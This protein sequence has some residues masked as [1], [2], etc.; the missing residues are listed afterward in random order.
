M[1]RFFHESTVLGS[2]ELAKVFEAGQSR[3]YDIQD[4][5]VVFA[6]DS[7]IYR[8]SVWNETVSSE[9]ISLF[10]STCQSMSL[11][12]QTNDGIDMIKF[13]RAQ[14]VFRF[15]M[16]YFSQGLSFSDP[17]DRLSFIK[18]SHQFLS[19]MAEQ[20]SDFAIPSLSSDTPVS[21]FHQFLAFYNLS[22]LVIAFQFLEIARKGSLPAMQ[23]FKSEEYVS[24]AAESLFQLHYRL[25][26][27]RLHPLYEGLRSFHQRET[28]IKSEGWILESCVIA[29]LTLHQARIDYASYENLS[30]L[31]VFGTKIIQLRNVQ[32]LEKAWQTIFTLLPLQ[33]VDQY[34]FV[35]RGF[36]LHFLTDN[37]TTV[38]LMVNRVLSL[39]LA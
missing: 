7:K 10:R 30:R 5:N 18:W 31:L 23:E 29:M 17:V 22:R 4:G 26:L 1:L 2:G 3:D 6:Q 33:E 15:F 20:F 28:G 13:Q 39:Y 27:G 32:D 21:S 35:K 9:L 8:W 12:D 11:A 14:T 16:R 25:N 37:W 38:K 34:G 19:D 36:R 24:S